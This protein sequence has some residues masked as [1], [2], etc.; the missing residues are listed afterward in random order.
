[1]VTV[2]LREGEIPTLNMNISITDDRGL[3]YLLVNI[4]GIEGYET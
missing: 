1:M 2:L 3:D 4:E